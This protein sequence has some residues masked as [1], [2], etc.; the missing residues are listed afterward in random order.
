MDP[1]VRINSVMR[2][3]VLSTMNWDAIGASAELAGALGVILTLIYLSSQLRQNT[4]ALRST[5]DHHLNDRI[6]SFWDFAAQHAPVIGHIIGEKIP[7]EKQT[8]QERLI[9][10]AYLMKGFYVLEE[11]LMNF[12]NG[13]ISKKQF[14]AKAG[15]FKVSFRSPIVQESWQRLQP[16]MSFTDEFCDF[17]ASEVYGDG[18]IDEKSYH[19]QLGGGKDA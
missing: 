18:E 2:H 7:Y 17:M 10:D 4:K 3:E 13:V 15:G 11:L 8:T 12:E 1:N 9:H 19:Y 6:D 5:A 16:T 14:E